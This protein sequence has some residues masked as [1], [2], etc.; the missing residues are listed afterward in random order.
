MWAN[1]T[2]CTDADLGAI[3]PLAVATAAPWGATTWTSARAEAKREIKVLIEMAFAKETANPADRVL[4]LHT[5]A[6]VLGLASSVYTDYTARAVNRDED[7]VDLTAIFA[8]AANKL[9]LACDYQFDGV[10]FLLKDALNAQARILTAKYSGPA[11]FTAISGASDGTAVTGKTLAQSGR[12]TWTTVPTD[13]QRRLVGTV[14]ADPF[15]WV[16]LSVDTALSA[17]STLAAQILT[18]R[19]PD[20]LRRVAQ[21]LSLYYVLNGLER[22][23]AKPKD[24]AE[25]A[26]GYRQEGLA[27][28]Q[29]LR[30][31]GGIPLDLNRDNVIERSETVHTAPLRL[32][33][34]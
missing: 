22:Q 27:L 5:P 24:W 2:L 28:F 7:D 34:A 4:D 32:G 19:V 12:V 23:A 10:A 33:R 13:W 1:L 3:E 11:G 17:G 25:K 16:E 29:A 9:Y 30:E 8:N 6:W 31:N 20:G 14:S 15:Y 21:L 18:V 26:I